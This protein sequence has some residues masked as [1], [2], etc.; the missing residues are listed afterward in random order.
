MWNKQLFESFGNWISHQSQC[1]TN[2]KNTKE[3]GRIDL[4]LSR[5]HFLQHCNLYDLGHQLTNKVKQKGFLIRLTLGCVMWPSS[6]LIE[7]DQIHRS[8][9]ESC[10]RALPPLR[11]TRRTVILLKRT[12]QSFS[13]LVWPGLRVTQCQGWPK[14]SVYISRPVFY[15]ER[16]TF[17]PSFAVSDLKKLRPPP[18]WGLV[19][20]QT[21]FNWCPKM[22]GSP[23]VYFFSLTFELVRRWHTSLEESKTFA[24]G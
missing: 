13:L 9:D 12:R 10:I 23:L 5:L 24:T 1:K 3:C 18:L 20:L 17:T 8:S 14:F 22:P 6:D 21:R 7:D 11:C 4:N 19:S 2:T 15:L 16:W